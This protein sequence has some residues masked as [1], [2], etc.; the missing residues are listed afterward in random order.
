MGCALGLTLSK[1][2]SDRMLTAAQIR[3]GRALLGWTAATLAERSR[4]SYAT[5]Q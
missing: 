5:V 3:A 2:D 4:V 1:D